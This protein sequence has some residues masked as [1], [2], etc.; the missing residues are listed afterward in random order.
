MEDAGLSGYIDEIKISTDSMLELYISFADKLAPLLKVE[1]D[2]SDKPLID[3]NQ[4]AEAYEALKEI[5]ASFDYDTAMYVIQSL[6][7]YK[8]PDSEKEK[9][10]AIKNAAMKPDWETLQ[11]LLE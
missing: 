7:E 5:S 8:L 3:D 11:K 1:E 4:L 2:D 6:E 10:T 9:F